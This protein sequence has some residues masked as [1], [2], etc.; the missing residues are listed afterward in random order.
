MS[1]E[2]NDQYNGCIGY[3][4]E[5]IYEP[6]MSMSIPIYWGNIKINED[7]NEGSFINWNHYGSD[8]KTIERIIEIDNDN[9]EEK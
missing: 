5:K 6:F 2:N 4:T 9:G 7:F 8:E 3:T 1:F